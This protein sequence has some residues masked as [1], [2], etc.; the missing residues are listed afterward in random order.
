MA[1]FNLQV[2]AASETHIHRHIFCIDLPTYEDQQREVK[3]S[4]LGPFHAQLG[5]PLVLSW[6]LTRPPLG[7]ASDQNET[8]SLLQDCNELLQRHLPSTDS[9]P[10]SAEVRNSSAD[11]GETSGVNAMAA[12]EQQDDQ[13]SYV[14]E[15]EHLKGSLTWQPAFERKGTIHLSKLPGSI[16]TIEMVLTPTNIGRLRPPQLVVKGLTREPRA[17][18]ATDSFVLVIPD[19]QTPNVE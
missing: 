4:F 13:E 7:F 18:G 8:M 6:Q 17:E 3:L 9:T 12:E 1:V 10:L 11:N 16:S 15:L 19:V 5:V 14:Y 2:P